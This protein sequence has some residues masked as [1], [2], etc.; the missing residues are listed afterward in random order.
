MADQNPARPPDTAHQR[1]DGS[2][3]DTV[4][5]V[6]KLSEAWEWIERARGRLYDF[7]QMMGHA[8]AML[9]E[10]AD[11]LEQA[12][13]VH[14]AERIRLDVVG[15]NVIHGRWTFQI[16]EEFDDDY[17]G[18]VGVVE[19]QVRDELMAGKRHVFEAELKEQRRTPGHPGHE[20]RP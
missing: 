1:P 13:H 9:G 3:D 7:H 6:G 12:G 16:V 8:D 5:A 18:P 11:A 2:S 17:Y 15:R 19:R 10:A 20:S 14:Q 4:T